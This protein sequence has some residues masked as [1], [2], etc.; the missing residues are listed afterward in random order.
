MIINKKICLLFC[1]FII[2]N[3]S[4]LG[5]TNDTIPIRIAKYKGDK[6]CAI[7]YTFDDGLKEHYILVAP[8]M[9]KYGF[10]GTFWIN[11]SKINQDEKN[12][13]DTTRMSWTQLKRMSEKGH[14]IS[15]HGWAHKNFS[16]HTL[17][18]I[19]EDIYKNDSAIYANIGIM[20]RTFCYPNNNKEAAGMKIAIKNRVGTRT[21]QRSIG[22][23]STPQDLEK[24]VRTLI[25]NKDWGVGMTHG[26]TY[27]YD[28]FKSPDVLWDHLEKVKGLE[29]SIWVETFHDIAAY[30]KERENIE[31]FIK[32]KKDKIHIM[33]QLLLDGNLFNK[34][35]TIVIDKK[36]VKKIIAK[37]KN[38]ILDT[39]IYPDKV[40]FDFDPHGGLIEVTIK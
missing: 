5:I 22:S 32:Q 35:L 28:A 12:I 24:W 27:G 18:Q 37:Q 21:K 13:H 40:I 33:P 1:S 14:E 8:Q 19:R 9:E 4:L 26:I 36:N 38:K 17:D 34:T 30:E 23:K 31:L 10:R 20:P 15:N 6:V 3:Y 2:F 29:D 16:R 25:T 11:G 7:S 39:Y